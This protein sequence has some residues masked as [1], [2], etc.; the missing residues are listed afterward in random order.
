M[1]VVFKQRQQFGLCTRLWV[2]IG[3]RVDLA[4][5]GG[6]LRQLLW[7]VLLSEPQRRLEQKRM[8]QK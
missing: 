4:V 1:F 5:T 2:V 6:S 3:Y 8:E 7:R